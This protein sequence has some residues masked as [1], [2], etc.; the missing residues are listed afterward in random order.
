MTPIHA[1]NIYRNSERDDVDYM[2]RAGKFTLGA[3]C[4][5]LL[6]TLCVNSAKVMTCRSL[7]VINAQAHGCPDLIQGES[8]T[9]WLVIITMAGAAYAITQCHRH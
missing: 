5:A 8:H 7:N 6:L 3:G 9:P 1:G 4:L 2:V